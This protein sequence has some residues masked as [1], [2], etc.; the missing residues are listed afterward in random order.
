[1]APAPRRQIQRIVAL[2]GNA[3]ALSIAHEALAV[4]A[5][6]GLLVPDGSRRRTPGGVFFHLVKQ[7][8]TRRQHWLLFRRAPSQRRTAEE[9]ARVLTW[10]NR[11]GAVQE[12]QMQKGEVDDVKITLVGRPGA[13][14]VR[15]N[16]V[17]TAMRS[18]RGPS[19]PNGLPAIPTTP[20]TYT[21]YIALKQWHTVAE[22]LADPDDALIVEGWA[23]FDPELEGIA[24]F[25]TYV[26]TKLTKAKEPGATQ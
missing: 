12:A 16:C 10:A 4:E 19:L 21:V 15:K 20:T 9:Y 1:S 18:T 22:A 24:V 5:L 14:A 26:T 2:V 11:M 6:G 25:A 23:A 8:V 3:R 7:Q 13:V 17:L